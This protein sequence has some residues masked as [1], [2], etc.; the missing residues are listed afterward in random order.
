MYL[1]NRA[2]LW[3]FATLVAAE[4]GINSNNQACSGKGKCGHIQ[5]GTDRCFL[6]PTILP[7]FRTGRV[8][9]TP[10]TGL[11]APW[12]T[13]AHEIHP[14]VVGNGVQTA[15]FFKENFG[16]TGRQ[17]AALL[18]G[19]HSF[20]KFNSANSMFKYSWTRHQQDYLNNQMFRHL[21]M[22]PQY[23][24]DCEGGKPFTLTGDYLGQPAETRWLV[25]GNKFTKSGGPFQ[26]GHWYMRC[27]SSNECSK[28]TIDEAIPTRNSSTPYPNVPSGSKYA[29]SRAEPSMPAGCCDDL[30]AGQRCSEK[31][32]RWI[33]NDETAL[34]VDTGYMLAFNVGIGKVDQ[35]CIS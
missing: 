33:V 4:S 10:E 28:I 22:K 2:D 8:D 26:W 15:D 17:G 29:T 14:S 16:L 6:T 11:A 35:T 34:S 12:E 18:V 3:A 31:C 5:A 13:S 30:E 25:R 21:A 7:V 20:G 32:Q 1:L 27:P 19:A 23:K 9:C 24:G